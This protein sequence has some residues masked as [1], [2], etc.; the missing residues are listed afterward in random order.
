MKTRLRKSASNSV[1]SARRTVRITVRVGLLAHLPPPASLPGHRPSLLHRIPVLPELHRVRHVAVVRVV[2][3][4]SR[5]HSS[6]AVCHLPRRP[7]AVP[8]RKSVMW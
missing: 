4:V 5:D 2:Q 1:P 8:I 7:L 6:V 3:A